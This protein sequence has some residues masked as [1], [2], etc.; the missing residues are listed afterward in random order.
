MTLE[1]NFTPPEPELVEP[2]TLGEAL[3]AIR[4]ELQ[5]TRRR[6]DQLVKEVADHDRRLGPAG[7]SASSGGSG[8]LSNPG[9]SS[10]GSSNGSSTSG[11]GTGGTKVVPTTTT[12]TPVPARDYL[13]MTV[14]FA[15]AYL[16]LEPSRRRGIAHALPFIPAVIGTIDAVATNNGLDSRALLPA[17]VPAAGGA[18]AVFAGAR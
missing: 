15:S 17:A 1:S 8:A 10:T 5:Y 4:Q 7:G 14:A 18:L 12:R 9:S 3:L 6:L 16:A 13:V 11:A 2:A